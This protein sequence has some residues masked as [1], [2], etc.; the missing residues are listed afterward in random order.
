M[1]ISA[2]M[3]R[4]FTREMTTLQKLEE[5][6]DSIRQRLTRFFTTVVEDLEKMQPLMSLMYEFY[7]LGLWKARV[8]H[9]L[10]AFFVRFIEIITPVIEEGIASDEF[11]PTDAR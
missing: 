1:F 9:V 3:E 7:A 5:T 11:I 10:G 6:E 2:L 4:L 8:R